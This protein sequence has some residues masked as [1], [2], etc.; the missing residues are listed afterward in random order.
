MWHLSV[1]CNRATIPTERLRYDSLDL[2]MEMLEKAKGDY[3]AALKMFKIDIDAAFRRVPIKPEHRHF[4]WVGFLYAG[5]AHAF[6][7]LAMPFGSIAAVH[8][9]DRAGEQALQLPCLLTL[10]ACRV[11]A[12]LRA[13]GRRILRIPIMRHAQLLQP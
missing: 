11:G 5:R 10:L 8:N 12:F 13:V 6:Q 2:F 3:N 4:A 9:W 7:H 1:S